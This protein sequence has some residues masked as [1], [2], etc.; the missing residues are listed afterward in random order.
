MPPWC[1]AILARALAKHP[2]NRFQTA[3][4]FKA[5]LA[6]SARFVTLDD[7]VTT[8]MPTPRAVLT[9]PLPSMPRSGGMPSPTAPHASDASGAATHQETGRTLVISARHMFAGI[10]VIVVVLAGIG[11]AGIVALRRMPATTDATPAPPAATTASPS[12][13]APPPAAAVPVPAVSTAT[14]NGPVA[15]PQ[16][17]ENSGFTAQARDGVPAAVVPGTKPAARGRPD[18]GAP[19]SGVT[20]VNGGAASPASDTLA[21]LA[22][23]KLKVLILDGTKTREEDGALHLEN[24]R[25]T[26]Y[27]EARRVVAAFP[28]DAVRGVTSARSRQPRWREPDGTTAEAKVGG[29]P[30]GFLKSDRN[31]FTLVTPRGP[32]IVRVDDARLR[33][34]SEA[35]TSRT[36][37]SVVR[38]VK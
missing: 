21:P 4:E 16:R 28:Y 24:G 37:A 7:L 2:G 19:S 35:V 12:S 17:S 27:G 22:F 29:G 15:S 36:G 18:A 33:S 30:L 38:L 10:G 6:A 23:D 25:V 3:Q 11:L 14:T 20:P 5:A 9:S 32:Y 13:I 31:W 26:I 1:D 8:T 34:L